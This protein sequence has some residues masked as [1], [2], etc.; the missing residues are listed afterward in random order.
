MIILLTRNSKPQGNLNDVKLTIINFFF[1]ACLVSLWDLISILPEE[2]DV[3]NIITLTL[4]NNIKQN[5]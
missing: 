3:I 1:I 5:E 2:D 4:T